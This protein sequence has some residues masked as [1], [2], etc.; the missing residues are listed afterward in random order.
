[1]SARGCPDPGAEK[2]AATGGSLL[3]GPYDLPGLRPAVLANP[4]GASFTLSQFVIVLR[5]V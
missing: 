5:G 2:A 1:M 3:P 4:I